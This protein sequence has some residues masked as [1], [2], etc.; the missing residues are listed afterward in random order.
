[1]GLA[2]AQRDAGVVN[3]DDDGIAVDRALVQNFETRALD[4]ADLSEL[5]IVLIGG[6]TARLLL[7]RLGVR[8][9]D[10]Q[11]TDG[12]GI[13]FGVAAT[14]DGRR[15]RVV[16]RPGSFGDDD[17]LS[18]LVRSIAPIPTPSSPAREGESA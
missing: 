7:D 15:I 11:G 8:H 6:E 16:T 1:M 4:E 12:G 18:A 13:V 2:A 14:E 9:V 17:Q 5:T 10:V 3:A